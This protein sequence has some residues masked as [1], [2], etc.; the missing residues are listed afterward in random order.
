MRMFDFVRNAVRVTKLGSG[1]QDEE[2]AAAA[3]AKYSSASDVIAAFS[4][5]SQASLPGDSHKLAGSHEQVTKAVARGDLYRDQQQ[6]IEARSAYADALALEPGLQ[7]IWI[8]LGHAAKESGD[9]DAAEWAYGQAL[10]IDNGDADGHLQLGH[11]HKLR[12]NLSA[13]LRSYTHAVALDHRLTDAQEEIARIK[14]RSNTEKA[15]EAWNKVSSKSAF[16]G[17]RSTS[18]ADARKAQEAAEL[19]DSLRDQQNWKAAHA[20]YAGAVSLDPEYQPIW[21]QLGHAA[22]ESGDVIGAELA[23]RRAIELDP[24]DPEAYNQLAHLLK[25]Q[26]R[27]SSA[28][29][30]YSRVVALDHKFVGAQADIAELTSRLGLDKDVG[31]VDFTS[32]LLAQAEKMVPEGA[33]S[34]VFE[35]SD[36]MSYFRGSRL[37]TGIQR[38]QMEVIRS[39][40]EG[41]PSNLVCSIVCFSPIQQFWIEV[42]ADLFMGFCGLAVSGGDASDRQWMFLLAELDGILMSEKY[43]GF[44]QGSILLD[45]GTSWW[46]RNYFLNIRFAKSLYG[47][48]YVP[49]VHDLIPI[50]TPEYCSQELRRDFL[51]WISGVLNHADGF[52]TNSQAT[53]KDLGTVSSKLGHQVSDVAVVTLNADFRASLGG[54]ESEYL[55]ERAPHFLMSRGLKKGEY[56]LCVA[57]IEARKN[58]AAAFAVWLKL[59]KKHGIKNVPMLVCVGK[60]GWLN[61]TAYEML[62]ASEILAGHVLIL[63]SVSDIELAVLYRNCKCTLYPSFYEGWGLPVSEAL[64]YGKIPITPHISSL[65]EAGEKFAEYFDIESEKDLLEAVER[66]ALYDAYRA[67]REHL[68]ATEYEPRSWKQITEQILVQLTAW[69]LDEWPARGVSQTRQAFSPATA[70]VGVLHFLGTGTV[71][72]LWAGLKNGEVYRLG[73][74]WWW[75]EEWGCWTRGGEASILS[76]TLEDVA[77]SKLLIYIGLKSASFRDVIATL[78]CEGARTLD[79]HLPPNRE[80][81]V[82]LEL[83]SA[84]TAERTIAISIATTPHINLSAVTGGGD[85]RVIG[86]GVSWFYACKKDDLPARM[87]IVEALSIGDFWRLAP[88]PPT[89]PDFFVHT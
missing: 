84:S 46:Q 72:I 83:D 34:I 56:V 37:P 58:H 27:L 31:G 71:A 60:D 68:I 15:G 38:V 39:V 35:V 36:L 21:I 57:T 89:Q 28:L 40:I 30:Y 6:W 67:A 10:E 81:V 87:A 74:G 48:K 53:A 85:T 22:K 88:Q 5:N 24:E 14:V 29:E 33:V 64:C 11:L 54:A 49:F 42:P 2:I 75:P 70:D 59:I 50:M 44:P 7:P 63:H 51:S 86:V 32:T 12:G 41:N 25:I 43:F 20:A 73:R 78:K 66:V 1:Q 79:V 13:A 19:G 62:R 26:G 23:Y 52:L 65:P 55:D 82:A 77:D 76:F 18:A 80:Q 4:T 45:L 47:I 17:A 8:Q 9:L 69:A 3:L 16:V 61:N